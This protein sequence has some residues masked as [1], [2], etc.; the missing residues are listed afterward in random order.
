VQ[1]E[2]LIEGHQQLKSYITN[3]Y[4]GLFGPSEE[5]LFS[6]DETL[7]DDIPQVSMDK[8]GLL[9]APYS[10]DE[11]HKAIFQMEHNKA[12]GPDGFPAEFYQTFWQTIN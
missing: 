7:T 4:K 1:D 8:N 6:L 9:S 3:Y 5:S 2:G 11:V 10:K 12:P